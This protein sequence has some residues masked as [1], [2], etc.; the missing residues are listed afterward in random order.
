MRTKIG[1][2]LEFEGQGEGYVTKRS[3]KMG[4]CI[5]LFGTFLNLLV[6]EYIPGL[7]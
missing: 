2:F 6:L 4:L 3:P 7:C 5:H 1:H